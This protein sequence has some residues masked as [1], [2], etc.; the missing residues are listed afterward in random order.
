M[1]RLLF[2]MGCITAYLY[3]DENKMVEYED[4]MMQ[5]R[6]GNYWIDVPE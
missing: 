5:K 4:Y 1:R 6:V 2:K 3:F